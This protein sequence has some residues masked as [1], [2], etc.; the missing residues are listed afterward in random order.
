M[1]EDT[2]VVEREPGVYGR[3]ESRMWKERKMCGCFCVCYDM[4][5]VERLGYKRGGR[6]GG[7]CALRVIK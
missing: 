7:V 3:R 5:C 4:V 6:A 2:G 1:E